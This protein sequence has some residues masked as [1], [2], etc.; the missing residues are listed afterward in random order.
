[1]CIQY[2]SDFSALGL[3]DIG[4]RSGV[5]DRIS[6]KNL[7]VTSNLILHILAYKSIHVRNF[8]FWII[9]VPKIKKKI[10]F[11]FAIFYLS[12]KTNPVMYDSAVMCRKRS[13]YTFGLSIEFY[14]KQRFIPGTYRVPET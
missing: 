6:K 7:K 1:M 9:W 3:M 10:F 12:S 11:R 14:C 4:Y 13:G 5:Q 8:G 2:T